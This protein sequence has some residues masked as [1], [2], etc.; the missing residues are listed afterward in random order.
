[1]LP[2]LDHKSDRI[3]HEDIVQGMMAW[4]DTLKGRALAEVEQVNPQHV[5]HKMSP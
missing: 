4:H 3:W 2:L 1:L 5:V